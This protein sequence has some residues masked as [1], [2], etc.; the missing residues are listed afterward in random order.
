MDDV[1]NIYFENNESNTATEANDLFTKYAGTVE[2][3]YNNTYSNED[4][5][6][7]DSYINYDRRDNQYRY[8][9]LNY[10]LTDDRTFFNYSPLGF[11]TNVPSTISRLL[12]D[13]C[14]DIE[15]GE[16]CNVEDSTKSISFQMEDENLLVVYEYIGYGSYNRTYELYFYINESNR[17]SLVVK[18]Q[19]VRIEDDVL[20][21]HISILNMANLKNHMFMIIM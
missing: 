14:K 7:I 11:I 13:T 5:Y 15:E 8:E 3:Y 4:L 19:D 2:H 21:H 17:T 10:H 18:Y 6:E 1:S 16:T 20:F 9:F 12:E